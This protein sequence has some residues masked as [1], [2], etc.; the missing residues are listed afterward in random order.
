M[1]AD[2]THEACSQNYGARGQDKG[3]KLATEYNSVEGK[4]KAITQ[5]VY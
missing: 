4:V 3:V 1:G 5:A 2:D